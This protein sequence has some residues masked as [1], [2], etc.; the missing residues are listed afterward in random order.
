MPRLA[1]NDFP[2]KV[3]VEA[4]HCH[5]IESKI[6]GLSFEMFSSDEDVKEI[7]SFNVLQIG[8]LA[9]QPSSEILKQYPGMP[10]KNIKGMRDQ[11]GHK[12]GTI[13]LEKVWNTAIHDI[14]PL[15]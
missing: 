5:R 7:I 6:E 12:Y 14:K 4:K 9:K 10:W 2:H 8:E 15:R 1:K 3:L 13:D 11:V